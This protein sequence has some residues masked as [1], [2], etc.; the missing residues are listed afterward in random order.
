MR[1]SRGVRVIPVVIEMFLGEQYRAG[2]RGGWE[3][4]VKTHANTGSSGSVRA[5]GTPPG[6]D[7]KGDLGRDG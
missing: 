2:T 5:A 6:F 7:E 4:F 1:F 3:S